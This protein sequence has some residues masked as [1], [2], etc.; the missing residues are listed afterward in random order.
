MVLNRNPDNFFAETEQVAFHPGHLVPGIDFTN[1]PLLQGRLFSYTDTQL[2]RLGSPNFHEIPINRPIA[3]MHNNQRDGHM[4]QEINV[5]RVSYSPNSLGGGCP[6]QAKMAEGGFVSVNERIDAHK[7]RERSDSFADHFSQ[8]ELFFKSQTPAEQNHIIK[9]LRFELSKVETAA[10]RERMVGLLSQ[11]DKS[12]AKKVADGLGISVPKPQKPMN[13]GIGADANPKKHEPKSADNSYAPS[14][15]LSMIDNPANTGSIESRTIAFL[16][17][18]GVNE[19]SVNQ[20]KKA[21]EAQGAAA[22]IIGPHA[23]SVVTD[24]GKEVKVDFAFFSSSSVLFDAVYIPNATN[25]ATLEANDNVIEFNNDAYRHCK[26]IGAEEGTDKLLSKTT[27]GNKLADNKEKT[28]PG[29]VMGG[30]KAFADEF[31]SELRKHRIW[32]REEKIVE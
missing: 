14:A 21:L 29:V 16:C 25:I 8:A 1:D 26:V 6:F 3:P 10:I 28:L 23:G 13:H 32:E 12:L 9:A 5:G 31:I 2:S 4:R 18:D 7:V 20:L 27:I 19:K 17:A 15:A 22:K 11:V 24:S 30:D